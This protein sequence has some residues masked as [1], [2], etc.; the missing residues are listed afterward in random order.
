MVPP[1]APSSTQDGAVALSKNPISF[2][3]LGLKLLI[4]V[5]LVSNLC[6]GTLLA[7]SWHANRQVSQKNEELTQLRETLSDNLREEIV[8]LQEKYLQI[9][10]LLK[11]DPTKN[12]HGLDLPTSSCQKRNGH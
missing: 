3:T 11:V 8:H 2:L 10:K 12:D 9:P 7:V 1:S 6:I 5:A 4:G